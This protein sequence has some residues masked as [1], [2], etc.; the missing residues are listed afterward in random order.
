MAS[1][2]RSSYSSTIPTFACVE[3]SLCLRL[4][5]WWRRVTAAQRIAESPCR[6]TSRETCSTKNRKNS[7]LTFK[8]HFHDLTRRIRRSS[9][10]A[11]NETRCS[12]SAYQNQSEA[13]AS[14]SIPHDTLSH[15]DQRRL[16]AT[17]ATAT[18]GRNAL[19]ERP[20]DLPGDFAEEVGPATCPVRFTDDG[21]AAEPPNTKNKREPPDERRNIDATSVSNKQRSA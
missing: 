11:V 16:R 5:A 19:P 1:A 21:S 18:R 9:E 10:V 12:G 3:E 20:A 7:F 17:A 14:Q 15:R 2:R 8:F 4:S 6:R 13:G